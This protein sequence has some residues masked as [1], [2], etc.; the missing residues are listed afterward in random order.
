MTEKDNI[1]KLNNFRDSYSLDAS[2]E[3][4]KFE[5]IFPKRET[6]I[7]QGIIEKPAQKEAVEKLYAFF[8]SIYKPNDENLCYRYEFSAYR[9]I[10]PEMQ[11]KYPET[12]KIFDCCSK[13][14][15]IPIIFPHKTVFENIM[16]K[17]SFDATRSNFVEKIL[18]VLQQESTSKNTI[19]V[20]H[21]FYEESKIF[22]N[23]SGRIETEEKSLSKYA[24]SIFDV[25]SSK[26][27]T[28]KRESMSR[29]PSQYTKGELLETL[30][31][32]NDKL[33]FLSMSFLDKIIEIFPQSKTYIEK[34]KEIRKQYKKEEFLQTFEERNVNLYQYLQ[35]LKI[36]EGIGEQFANR[37]EEKEKNLFLA[38]KQNLTFCDYNS[39]TGIWKFT[40][41]PNKWITTRTT[42][43]KT[44]YK[45][46]SSLL[47]EFCKE[48][49]LPYN[50]RKI[51]STKTSSNETNINIPEYMLK[52][53][54]TNHDYLKIPY[55]DLNNYFSEHKNVH[56][57]GDLGMGKDILLSAFSSDFKKRYPNMPIHIMDGTRFQNNYKTIASTASTENKSGKI[58]TFLEQFHWVKLFII[59]N[60]HNLTGKRTQKAFLDLVKQN[61][62]QII[63]ISKQ[64]LRDIKRSDNGKT[65]TE[66][67]K[68][69]NPQLVKIPFPSN[70]NRRESQFD[71]RRNAK[72][73]ELPQECQN[74]PKSLFEWI[75]KFVVNSKTPT[76]KYESLVNAVISDFKR[77]VYEEKEMNISKTAFDTLT[78]QIGEE[79][80]PQ[81]EDI[82][83]TVITVLNDLELR[84]IYLKN[85]YQENRPEV[86][87]SE[88]KQNKQKKNSPSHIVLSLIIHFYKEYYVKNWKMNG[89]DI[90]KEFDKPNIIPYIDPL[91]VFK[92]NKDFRILEKML[93]EEIISKTNDYYGIQT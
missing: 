44:L 39:T 88:I 24:K 42:S 26:E 14:E 92:T 70:Q 37:L 81:K 46:L 15:R 77:Y 84:K 60:I 17:I 41:L 52:S 71:E 5:D 72:F 73:I 86:T 45:Q 2:G 50:E 19:K 78:F 38:F 40:P 68:L 8:G 34:L 54:E 22:N 35:M 61:Q 18:E 16:S 12:K 69:F 79:P 90:A 65:T 27:I 1:Q 66:F 83:A 4:S 20:L 74:F 48:N 75:K 82:I 11:Q 55:Q 67:W 28:L 36:E 21:N 64:N 33:E 47:S 59:E 80:L 56:L 23:F 25:L 51:L 29:E 93:K 89:K 30:L 13:N 87:E 91:S 85:E 10:I 76:E 32:P 6:L 7:T 58:E 53:W 62:A 31:F 63:G 43:I 57:S 3:F 9:H 49:N